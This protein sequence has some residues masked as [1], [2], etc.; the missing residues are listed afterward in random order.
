M[1]MEAKCLS[2]RSVD[3]STNYP[4][5]Y[6]PQDRILHNHRYENLKRRH[7]RNYLINNRGSCLSGT[8]FDFI[9]YAGYPGWIFYYFLRLHR[10]MMTQ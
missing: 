3:F 2:E 6:F 8:G 7:C 4:V 10:P 9:S 1:K 5:L